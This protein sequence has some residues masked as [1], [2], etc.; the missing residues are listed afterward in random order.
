MNEDFDLQ[1]QLQEEYYEDIKEFFAE[2]ALAS[3]R[4]Y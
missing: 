2:E 1:E 3:E 4:G